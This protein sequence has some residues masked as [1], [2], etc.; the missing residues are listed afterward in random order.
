MNNN[1]Q[2]NNLYPDPTC[3]E[4]GELCDITEEVYDGTEWESWCY[5]KECIIDTFHSAIGIC[6]DGWKVPD[7]VYGSSIG[8]SSETDPSLI[9]GEDP[10][11]DFG[12][13]G[14]DTKYAKHLLIINTKQNAKI[15]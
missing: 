10:P 12:G 8:P 11:L 6:E 1:R 5:C 15:K 9:G 2:Y 14:R 13:K 3:M 4:C 7:I